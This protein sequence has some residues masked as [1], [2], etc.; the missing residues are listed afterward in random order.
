MNQASVGSSSARAAWWL[1]GLFAML[2]IWGHSQVVGT[3]DP[4][5]ANQLREVSTWSVAG[6]WPYLEAAPDGLHLHT[7]GLV[8]GLLLSSLVVWIVWRR[9]V[10][11]LAAS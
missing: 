8:I 1:G 6:R 9:G 5:A 3:A 2:S 7:T 11:R 4:K 10:G